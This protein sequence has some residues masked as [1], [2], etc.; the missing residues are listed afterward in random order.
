MLIC[1]ASYKEAI[2]IYQT[3]HNWKFLCS[4]LNTH[5]LSARLWNKT[6]LFHHKVC[7]N[8]LSTLLIDYCF[9]YLC[10][11]CCGVGCTEQFE[12][13]TFAMLYG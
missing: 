4:I 7:V 9:E 3:V 10:H 2:I 1:N 13:P 12:R 11:L 5:Q 8:W 6:F